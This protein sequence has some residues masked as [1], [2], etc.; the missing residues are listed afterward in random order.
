MVDRTETLLLLQPSLR[1]VLIR[2][3]PWD[4][5]SGLRVRGNPEVIVGFEWCDVEERGAWYCEWINVA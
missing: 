3:C 5:C 1:I 2:E 4:V